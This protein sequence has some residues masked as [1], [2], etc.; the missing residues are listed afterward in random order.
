MY[1]LLRKWLPEPVANVLIVAWYVLLLI[2][3]LSLCASPPG[4]FRYNKI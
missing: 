3:I 4:D 1:Q 2:T